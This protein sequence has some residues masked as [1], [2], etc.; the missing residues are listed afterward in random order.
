MLFKCEVLILRLQL[1]GLFLYSCARPDDGLTWPK[2]VADCEFI[3]FRLRGMYHVRL[4]NVTC[5]VIGML[6]VYM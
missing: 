1:Y 2:H 6:H 5:H 3:G 4:L